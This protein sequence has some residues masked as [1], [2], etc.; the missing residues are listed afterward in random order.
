MKNEKWIEEIMNVSP[1]D[2]PDYLQE[3]DFYNRQRAEDLLR[4]IDEKYTGKD[5]VIGSFVA[6]A[7]LNILTNV[8]RELNIKPIKKIMNM[9]LSPD[10]VI[11]E[12]SNFSYDDNLENEYTNEN[13]LNNFKQTDREYDRKK[14]EDKQKLRKYREEYFDSKTGVD[15]Y[16]G[17]RIYDNK[18]DAEARNY[19]KVTEHVQNVDHIM[20]LKDKFDEISNVPALSDDDIKRIL[21][22][23]ENYAITNESLN[24]SKR[25][26][27]NSDY[28]NKNKDLDEKTKKL[29]IEKE[30]SANK[31]INKEVNKTIVKN[32]GVDSVNNAVG[33]VILL[34]IKASYYEVTDSI[35][36]GVIHKTNTTTKIA[37]ASYRIKRVIKYVLSKIKD[38]FTENI[39]EFLKSMLINF[40]SLLINMLVD[41]FKNIAKIVIGG[42]DAIIQAVKIITVPSDTMTAAQKSDAIVKLIASTAVLFIGDITKT[43][44]TK[45]GVPEKFIGIANAFTLGIISAVIGYALDKIDLFGAKIDTRMQRVNEIFNERIDEIEKDA[46]QFKMVTIELLETQKNMFDDTKG[47]LMTSIDN[48]DSQGVLDGSYELSKFFNV[49][50]GYSN[51]E[52]FTEYLDNNPVIEF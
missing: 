33:D 27:K 40:A 35:R 41:V 48:D 1:L 44:L 52:E 31:A 29:M 34:G 9:G 32:I 4:E 42:I 51:S 6:P 45:V 49:D 22:I 28:I 17:K 30:N 10:R 50:L 43:L 11:T 18:S 25:D 38:V 3:C 8:G 46:E 39:F 13:D 16:T 37:E 24:K 19:T 5:G 12:L 36:N 23:K 15:E 7:F 21:N 26:A 47:K 14:Y 2:L 20:P